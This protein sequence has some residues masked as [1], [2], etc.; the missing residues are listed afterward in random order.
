MPTLTIYPTSVK[1]AYAYTTAQ[2]ANVL[3]NTTATAVHTGVVTVNAA[4]GGVLY[5]SMTDIPANAII[6]SIQASIIVSANALSRRTAYA[7][8]LYKPDGGLGIVNYI[9]TAMTTSLVQYNTTFTSAQL[10]AAGFTTAA[11]RDNF[12]EWTTTLIS[13]NATSTTTTWQK[14]FLTITY[15]LTSG[16]NALFYGENF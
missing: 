4:L 3:G 5:F 16:P 6:T 1:T 2:L 13:T 8:D 7:I 14:L 11:L 15:E 12:I 10:A 9:N